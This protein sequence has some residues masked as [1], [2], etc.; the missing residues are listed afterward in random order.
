MN[1]KARYVFGLAAL[2]ALLVGASL[3]ASASA[4]PAW[5]FN[6]KALEGAESEVIL[7]GAVESGLTV[8]GLTTTCE[9]FLYELSVSNSAGTG[10]GSLTEVPLFNCYTDSKACTV[11]SIG[12]ETLPWT[13]HLTNVS[14]KPYI[15]IEGVK[16]GIYYEGAECVLGET[17]VTVKGSA[18]GEINN[19]TES[20]T[21]NAATLAA[22][23]TVLKALGSTKLEWFGVFPT[24]GF[25]LRRTQPI[26]VS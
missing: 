11:G 17:L 18:G 13:S 2:V 12:A 15:V 9:D 8:P 19:A 7:G 14:S 4:A 22:T 23:G 5:K 24:E 20:A 16:V 10:Q 1:R 6:E 21:F 3:A 25:Q 26:N